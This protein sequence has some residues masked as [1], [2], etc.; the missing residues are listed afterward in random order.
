LLDCVR[1]VNFASEVERLVKVFSAGRAANANLRYAPAP[2]L[3]NAREILRLVVRE[4]DA[5]GELGPWVERRV[6]ELDLETT[7]VASV[8]TA[9]FPRVAA[10]RF[11]AP[12]GALADATDVLVEEWLRPLPDCRI[13]DGE[14]A[15]ERHHRADDVHDPSSLFSVFRAKLAELHVD[16]DVVLHAD[17]PSVAAAST[18]ALHVRRGAELTLS[19]ARRIAEHEIR[20]HLLPRRQALRANGLLRC[21]C[22]GAG[23]EEEG[24]AVLIEARS[25]SLDA[26]RKRELALRHRA[27]SLSR[28][29]AS[30]VDVVRHLVDHRSSVRLAVTTCL[31]CFRGAPVG[32]DAPGLGREI[33]YLP[34]FLELS[35]A[36]EVEP[37]RELWFE[38]GRCSLAY[39]RFLDS[40]SVWAN[41]ELGTEGMA[42]LR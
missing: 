29:G 36:F 16:A 17:L 20:A 1:P 41:Y 27:C 5:M 13:E 10:R 28:R 6:E 8:G 37:R 3:A 26:T 2:D 18:D 15:D 35:G 9:A 39:A 21:G 33:V 38:R 40:H 25:R 14:V 31:R 24:R 12:E 19:Q 34:A 30:F 4:T 22:A 23:T 7:L 42:P 32:M 11:S